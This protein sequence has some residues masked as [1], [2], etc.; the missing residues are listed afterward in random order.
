MKFY[1]FFYIIIL[2]QFLNE[3]DSSPVKKKRNCPLKECEC[4]WETR[5]VECLCKTDDCKNA[6]S[7]EF[8]TAQQELTSFNF[9]N[10]NLKLFEDIHISN[11]ERYDRNYFRDSTF[12]NEFSLTLESVR[13]IEKEAFADLNGLV[14]FKIIYNELDLVDPNAFNLKCD[15]FTLVS[16]GKGYEINLNV[17]SE[18]TGINKLV[19]DYHS[20]N[21]IESIFTNSNFDTSENKL[22]LKDQ[23]LKHWSSNARI[24]K[25]LIQNALGVE[26]LDFKYAPKFMNL[27]EIEI[28]HSD[29]TKISPLFGLLHADSLKRLIIRNSKLELVES[30]IFEYLNELDYLDLSSNPIKSFDTEAFY[31]L[32]KLNTL[33]LKSISDTYVIDEQ[34]L[35]M[36]TYLPC[37]V[38]VN[39]DDSDEALSSCALIYLH[40]LKNDTN[41]LNNLNELSNKRVECRLKEKVNFCIELSQRKA[42]DHC[43]ANFYNEVEVKEN[44]LPDKKSHKFLHAPHENSAEQFE[45]GE[46]NSILADVEFKYKNKTESQVTAHNVEA[47]TRIDTETSTETTQLASTAEIS[48]TETSSVNYSNYETAASYTETSSAV[49]S[50]DTS[51][52]KNV[53]YELTSVFSSEETE[54]TSTISTTQTTS[55]E[56]T[57][58]STL[59]PITE[60][61]S[62]VNV[63]ITTKLFDEPKISSTFIPTSEETTTT[64]SNSK[65]TSEFASIIN[66]SIKTDEPETTIKTTKEIVLT[67]EPTT[68]TLD[69]LITQTSTILLAKTDSTSTSTSSEPT[70]STSISIASKET[71]TVYI[72]TTDRP[73][74]S[75]FLLIKTDATSTTEPETSTST[76]INIKPKETS[77]V[78]ISESTSTTIRPET[79][80][81]LLIKTVAT[82]KTELE[83]STSIN[84]IPKETSTV[85]IS[86]A[87]SDKFESSTISLTKIETTSSE[88]TTSIDHISSKESSTVYIPVVTLTTDKFETSTSLLN[89]IDT[90][91]SEPTTSLN[92]VISKETSTDKSEPST[93]ISTKTSFIPSEPVTTIVTTLESSTMVSTSLQT[94]K[95]IT[96]TSSPETTSSST[97]TTPKSVFI[98]KETV[99][100]EKLPPTTSTTKKLTTKPIEIAKLK[101]TTAV[102]SKTTSPFKF[103]NKTNLVSNMSNKLI[104]KSTSLTTHSKKPLLNNK[105]TTPKAKQTTK[106]IP[107]TS[108]HTTNKGVSISKSVSLAKTQSSMA[109]TKIKTTSAYSTTT[110]IGAKNQEKNINLLKLTSSENKNQND[111]DKLLSP[112]KGIEIPKVTSPISKTT[113]PV[114]K[115]STKI[116]EEIQK[117]STGVESNKTKKVISKSFNENIVVTENAKA[118]LEKN[119]ELYLVIITS[120]V[121]FCIIQF[122]IGVLAFYFFYVR[123][124]RS[125]D[126]ILANFKVEQLP[127]AEVY[128][129]KTNSAEN[130]EDLVNSNI[131]T[132]TGATGSSSTT[133][134]G[135][136]TTAAASAIPKEK[137]K[138]KS[139]LFKNINPKFVP[140]QP[141]EFLRDSTF[142]NFFVKL[143]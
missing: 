117:D 65:E 96:D 91:S 18:N 126:S 3:L 130:S 19:L 114:I 37:K 53:N 95:Q 101:Q 111:T 74:T 43:L 83:T 94:S 8:N 81:I 89:K 42:A 138:T 75:A 69:S 105:T 38:S 115:T 63:P 78:Y 122:L 121:I 61:T 92:T 70:T 131:N 39:L 107:K 52:T 13:K 90:T 120:L 139:A 99:I 93:I 46:H 40:D 4:N 82:T 128:P 97:Q 123:R 102:K 58:L 71:S 60:T 134:A 62:T 113:T 135:A 44:E 51:S 143:N 2:F 98:P 29:I 133:A 79:S 30:R 14:N 64:N 56:T 7:P 140:R 67:T 119:N 34:D 26:L 112:R 55:T 15:V 103:S 100:Y 66:T 104:N 5:K 36:L 57:T 16:E 17:F 110:T 23:I 31:G 80:A 59:E 127:E 6:Y 85:H 141:I 124:C 48:S 109:K 68:S 9:S 73:E 12:S 50:T 116:I 49:L 21:K 142:K 86:V 22:E 108:S 45:S 84:I 76:S 129:A 87:T 10:K 106:N 20:S 1:L 32:N 47:T 11:V 27:A 41:E 33:S 88:S 77:T 28:N 25:I 54:S 132:V 137:P 118:D 35:C 24:N 72:P 136:T 125:L